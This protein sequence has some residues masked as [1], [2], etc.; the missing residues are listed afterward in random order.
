MSHRKDKKKKC[1]T[2]VGLWDLNLG[3]GESSGHKPL[4]CNES[5]CLVSRMSWLSTAGA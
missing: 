2:K 3:T 1:R 5:R 4:L